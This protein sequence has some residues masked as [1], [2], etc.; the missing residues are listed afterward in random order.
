MTRTPIDSRQGFPAT[1]ARHEPTFVTD[2][3]AAFS[4]EVS[5]LATLLSMLD[6][7]HWDCV[8]AFR[9]WTIHDVVLHLYA[10]DYS[11]VVSV[12]NE[13]AFQSLR[14]DI[15]RQR[16]AG[17]SMLDESKHRFP[18]LDPADL[19]LRWRQQ[20]FELCS[21][22][23]DRAPNDRVAW[24]GPAMSVST[25]ASARQM[26]TWAHGQEIYDEL[27]IDRVS[28]DRLSHI[29]LLGF[30]T[31]G[32]SFRNRGLPVPVDKPTV[33]LTLPSGRLVVMNEVESNENMIEGDA[34][35]F[36]QVVTQVRHIDDT[37]LRVKGA[38]ARE[39]MRIVQCFAG[40]PVDPPP[41]GSRRKAV[42]P[43]APQR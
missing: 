36:C 41:A 13:Q 4:T 33:A 22:L 26:E 23:D 29:A 11:A 34:E 10:S 35:A 2:T 18:D 24:S 3:V 43:P 32:W 14:A 17:L 8:T 16:A 19:L 9:G 25:L 15:Q 40:P 30:K 7:E 28:S 27:G 1:A 5:E 6:S 38:V 12:K 31:F 21:L 39:W 42:Q 37:T 20:A